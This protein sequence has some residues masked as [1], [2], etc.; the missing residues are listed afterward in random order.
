VD[1]GLLSIEQVVEGL[2]QRPEQLHVICTGRNAHPRLIEMADLVSEVRLI[3][4]PYDKGIPAQRGI[5]Y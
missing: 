4:H 1:Y 5:E 2:S 3:K